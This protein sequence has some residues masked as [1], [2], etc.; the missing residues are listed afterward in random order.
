MLLDDA[1]R[2]PDMLVLATSL[3][4][5]M[6]R[7][8]YNL[9]EA[10]CRPTQAALNAINDSLSIND[11]FLS[12]ADTASTLTPPTPILSLS[13]RIRAQAKNRA[14]RFLSCML[15]LGTWVEGSSAT[16]PFAFRSLA[17]VL[18]RY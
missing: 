9:T 13:F 17:P 6:V 15:H 10:P 4:D 7:L 1:G 2:P 14:G 18:D 11:T 16:R 12:A 3:W 8:P 5:M